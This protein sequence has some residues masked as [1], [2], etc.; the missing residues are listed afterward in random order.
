MALNP[1]KLLQ[2][3]ESWT[4]FTNAHPKFPMFLK[5]ISNRDVFAP[6]TVVEISINTA[7]GRNF[8][9]NV[10]I[11]EEDLQLFEDVKELMH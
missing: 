5:A 8:T 1:M 11:S 2:L 9:T 10:K 4:R 7:D 6:G 3:K